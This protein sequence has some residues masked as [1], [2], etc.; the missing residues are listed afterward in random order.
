MMS[1]AGTGLTQ[2]A[3]SAS[4]NAKKMALRE[5]ALTRTK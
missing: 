5:A 4:E 2:A 3:L 1:G